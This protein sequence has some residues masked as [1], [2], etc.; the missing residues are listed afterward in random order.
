[1]DISKFNFLKSSEFLDCYHNR[2]HWKA[3]VDLDLLSWDDVIFCIDKATQYDSGMHILDNFG[4][5]IHNVEQHPKIGAMLE[6]FSKLDPEYASDARWFISMVSTSACFPKHQDYYDVWYWQVVGEID[7]KIWDN[8]E[9]YH[10]KLKSNDLI[11]IP[12][13]MWH[14]TFSCM[15]RAGISFGINKNQK[16]NS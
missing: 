8:T 10:Y 3:S 16:I 6:Q 13:G 5:I 2:K 1:M 15:P 9:E 12:K 14:Q 7:W 4:M 11:F